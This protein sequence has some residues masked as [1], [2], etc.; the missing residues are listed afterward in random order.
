MIIPSTSEIPTTPTVKMIVFHTA[1]RRA[2]SV[3]T[4]L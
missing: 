1:W 2:G 3:N 4:V